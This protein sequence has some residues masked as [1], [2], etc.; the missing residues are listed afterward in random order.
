MDS[1]AEKSLETRHA[2]DCQTTKIGWLLNNARICL[3][4]LLRTGWFTLFMFRV[5]QLINSFGRGN[6]HWWV[7]SCIDYQVPAYG[8]LCRKRF[9]NMSRFSLPKNKDWLTAKQCQSLF[10]CLLEQE[11]TWF[12][13]QDFD[14]ALMA[15]EEQRHFTLM[16]VFMFWL[17]VWRRRLHAPHPWDHRHPGNKNIYFVYYLYLFIISSYIIYLL[18]PEWFMYQK[19]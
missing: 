1:C 14:R 8:F 18:F 4:C 13:L 3:F 16:G 7:C 10:V 11:F 9:G 6:S 2:L 5:W 19:N 12:H 15:S 17:S